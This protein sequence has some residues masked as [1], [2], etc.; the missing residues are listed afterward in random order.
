MRHLAKID[1]IL[2]KVGINTDCYKYWQ[3][4]R[5]E[6]VARQLEYNKSVCKYRKQCIVEYP[7]EEISRDICKQLNVEYTGKSSK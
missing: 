7:G 3:L 4:P 1:V 2:H 5:A 6:E